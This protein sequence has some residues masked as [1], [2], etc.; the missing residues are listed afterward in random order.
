MVMPKNYSRSRSGGSQMATGFGS[1]TLVTGEVSLFRFGVAPPEPR[2]GHHQL[3]EHGQGAGLEQ[4]RYSEA[5]HN[6][7]T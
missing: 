2:L 7:V 4:Q 1:T 6:M 3:T 5:H